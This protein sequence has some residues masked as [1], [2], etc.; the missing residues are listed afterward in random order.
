M[1]ISIYTLVENLDRSQFHEIHENSEKYYKVPDD[2]VKHIFILS[3]D[4]SHGAPWSK[5]CHNEGV[6][7]KLGEE[8]V[9]ESVLQ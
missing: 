9:K 8:T 2:N 5:P 7:V 1:C 3:S 4:D 6:G